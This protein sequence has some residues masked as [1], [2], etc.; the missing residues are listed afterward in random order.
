[1]QKGLIIHTVVTNDRGEV[2]ILQRSKG[3]DVLPGYWDLP[4]GTL[5]DG[6]DPAE[7]AIREAK[8]ETGLH[9]SDVKLFFHKSNVDTLKDKQ[10]VTLIFHTKSFESSVV[11]NPEE[12]DAYIWIDILD[13]ANY[14]TVEYL[15]GCLNAYKELITRPRND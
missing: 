1:M 14:Q 12:H 15:P 4:G 11:V 8:E 7:G 13:I 9:I 6:E 5:E 10:F 2:L 3:N